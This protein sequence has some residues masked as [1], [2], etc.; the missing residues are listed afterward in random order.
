MIGILNPGWEVPHLW[1]DV[2]WDQ[3]LHPSEREVIIDDV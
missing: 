2:S 3:I 1:F